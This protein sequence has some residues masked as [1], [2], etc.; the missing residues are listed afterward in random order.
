MK[1]PTVFKGDLSDDTLPYRK[2]FHSVE[3]YMK[4]HCT[5]FE[6]D[7]DKINWIEGVMDGKTGTWYD[8]RAEYMKKYFKVDEW[9]PFVSAMEERFLERQEERKALGKMREVKF[10][11]D[12]ESYLTDMET[13]NYKVCLVGTPWR[14]LLRD[15]LSDDLQYCLSTTKRE[16]RNYIDYS[17]ECS[18]GWTSNG[19][20]PDVAKE[21]LFK[22]QLIRSQEKRYE[23]KASERRGSKR[24]QTQGSWIRTE[25]Y[26]QETPNRE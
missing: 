13:H 22:G 23:E 18:K 2:W 12:I 10:K 16:P 1:L 26:L 8:A 21:V 14:T 17:R 5:D 9:N 11:G 25:V 24:T 19:R 4:W 20:I 3:N 6:D 15:G 7:I